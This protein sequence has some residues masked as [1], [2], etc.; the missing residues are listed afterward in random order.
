MVNLDGIPTIKYANQAELERV[1]AAL[2]PRHHLQLSQGFTQINGEQW[3]T[4]LTIHFDV[5]KPEKINA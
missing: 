1:W 2:P 4:S 5:P 3:C